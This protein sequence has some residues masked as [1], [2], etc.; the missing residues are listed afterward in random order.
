MP[1]INVR[2]QQIDVDI[3]AE[4]EQYEWTRPRW[5]ADK[6]LAGSPFRHD[7][8]PSFFANL[9]SGG[10]SDAGFYDADFAKG[11]FVKLLA[12]L[13]DEP[14][15]DTEDYL[16]ATYGGFGYDDELTLDLNRYRAKQ[17]LVVLDEAVVPPLAQRGA[18][19]LAKRGIH[20]A[21]TA[22]NGVG[23]DAGS[24]AVVIG[25]RDPQGRLANV[26]YRQVFGK[27]FWYAKGGRSLRSLVWGADIVYK[28]GIKRAVLCEAEFDA[29]TWQSAGIA[30][31][32]V[33]GVTFTQQQADIIKRSTIE[34]LILGGDN[35]KAGAK[36]NAEVTRLLGGHVRLLAPVWRN[37]EGAPKDA[38]EAGV[39]ALRALSYTEITPVFNFGCD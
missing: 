23:Y 9:D 33:G 7:Q 22:L 39:A 31:L 8:T 5:T 32:A 34:V 11:N 1:L 17:P 36:L 35:D 27:T 19:Y 6:L 37:C 13:R 20:P 26:K 38:N 18:D 28:R 21:V 2:Q 4:L 29:M 24:Q 10:W 16:L 30:G 25:W 12:F 15:V 3:T 14:T